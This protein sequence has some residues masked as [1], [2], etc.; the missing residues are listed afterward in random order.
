MTGQPAASAA[1]VSPPATENASGK[2]LAPNTTTG[3]NG[4]LRCRRSERGRGLRS[5]SAGSIR[6]P[7]QPPR[8]TSSANSRSCPMVLARSPVSRASGKPDS[9]CARSS[10][11]SPNASMCL[12]IVSRKR[13]RSSGSSSRNEWNA[14]HASSQ[15]RS[16]SAAPAALKRGCRSSPVAAF[17]AWK[18]ASVAISVAPTNNF[19]ETG[20][21]ASSRWLSL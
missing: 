20:I 3:P 7:S 12:A 5:G 4:T 8:R 14:R 19:P 16:T 17:T 18:P 10:N 2:L 13:A 1:A 21:G 11:S 15:A 9:A 6:S